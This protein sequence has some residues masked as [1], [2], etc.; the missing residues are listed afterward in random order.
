MKQN[1]IPCFR[2]K[3]VMKYGVCLASCADFCYITSIRDKLICFLSVIWSLFASWDLLQRHL[4][5]LDKMRVLRINLYACLIPFIPTG[6]P[7]QG[8]KSLAKAT[9]INVTSQTKI[10]LFYLTG[11]CISRLWLNFVIKISFLNVKCKFVN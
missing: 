3:I 7:D 6:M 5:N 9:L 8:L 10:V 11:R 2:I 1:I 4:C